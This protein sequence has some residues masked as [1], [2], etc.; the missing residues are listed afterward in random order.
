M[1]VSPQELVSF[2]E[3]LNK[4]DRNIWLTY[5][6]HS[7]IISFLDLTIYVK[8]NKIF[9]KTFRKETAANTLLL[10]TSHH[11]KSLFQGI[12]VGQFLITKRN[13]S[14]EDDFKAEVQQLIGRF[15]R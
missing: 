3:E 2:I 10:A 13:C 6:F 4:N 15:S 14:N 8:D 7:E 1:G 12:P 9:A 11:P 5:S